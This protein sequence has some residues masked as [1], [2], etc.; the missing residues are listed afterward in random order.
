MTHN[1]MPFLK[2]FVDRDKRF[3]GLDLI[4]KDWLN[5][6]SGPEGDRRMVIPSVHDAL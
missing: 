6:E 1:R 5:A 3:E 4:R 2:D